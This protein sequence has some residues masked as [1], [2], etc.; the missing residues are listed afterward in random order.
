MLDDT[1]KPAGQAPEQSAIAAVC[2]RIFRHVADLKYSQAHFTWSDE[3]L[4][5]EPLEALQV[6]SLTLLEF[7]MAVEEEFNVEIDE[8]EVNACTNVG[9]LVRLVT[10]ARDGSESL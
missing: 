4:L 7:V 10:A 6:D 2:A 8:D 3:R 1:A 9:D 5:Q